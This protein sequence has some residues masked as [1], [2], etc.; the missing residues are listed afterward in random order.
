MDKRQPPKSRAGGVGTV[1]GNEG[2]KGKIKWRH[3]EY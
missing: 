2:Y 1:R 3:W